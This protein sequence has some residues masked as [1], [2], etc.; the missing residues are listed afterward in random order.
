PSP[1]ALS[2]F[3]G[4]EGPTS[5]SIAL[6]PS[7]PLD[8]RRKPVASRTQP[9]RREFT[10]GSSPFQRSHGRAARRRSSPRWLEPPAPQRSS[11]IA[12]PIPPLTQSV[13]NPRF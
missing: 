1:I 8:S 3:P 4:A 5:P 7:L 9:T 13:A 2:Q 10:L 6:H 12:I 11:A